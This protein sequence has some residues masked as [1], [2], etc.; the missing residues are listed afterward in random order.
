MKWIWLNRNKN[1]K[2]KNQYSKSEVMCLKVEK[3]TF[4]NRFTKKIVQNLKWYNFELFDRRILNGENPRILLVPAWHRSISSW[5]ER[6]KFQSKLDQRVRM[7]LT[8]VAAL[9]EWVR[10][11]LDGSGVEITNMTTS[12]KDGLAFCALIHRY[13]PDLI[14][15]DTLNPR[16][17][18]RYNKTVH[19]NQEM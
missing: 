14:D 2:K 10:R 16:E 12:W 1:W 5:T 3:I 8:G 13:R 7:S 9:E 15:L 4:K 11:A 17:Y 19:T 6:A 18:R